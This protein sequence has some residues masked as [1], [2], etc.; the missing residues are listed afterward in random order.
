MNAKLYYKEATPH[1]LNELLLQSSHI[2]ANPKLVPS[3][4]WMLNRINAWNEKDNGKSRIHWKRFGNLWG[5]DYPKVLYALE[6]LSLLKVTRLKLEYHRNNH[7]CYSYEVTKTAK[8]AL[9]DTNKEYLYK[10]LTD[11]KQRRKTT[12]SI[13]KRGYNKQHFGDVRDFLKATVDGISFN[14]GD[15]DKACDCMDDGK[16]AFTYS[17]LISIVKKDYDALDFNAKDGRVWT[18]YAQ[19]PPEIKAIIKV[20]GLSLQQVMDIRSCYPSLWAK[21]V[22]E[23]ICNC[24]PAVAEEVE[25]YNKLFLVRENDPKQYLANLLGIDRNAIKEVLIKYFNGHRVSKKERDPFYKFDQYLQATFPLLYAT[26]QQSD[27]K[28]TGNNIGKYFETRLMLD[29][30]IYEKA[31]L[32][33]IVIGYEYD[34]MSFYSKDKSNCQALISFIEAKSVELLGIK[35]VFVD[36]TKFDVSSILKEKIEATIIAEEK[37][38]NNYRKGFFSKY[39]PS[40]DW[41]A[42]NARKAAYIGNQ[43]KRFAM[44]EKVT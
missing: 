40:K 26:W 24:A 2:S 34:G 8:A 1:A 6:C 21:Y 3:I 11:P 17:L 7:K 9:R 13:S 44:L 31:K 18:P 10:L 25:R 4:V 43:T 39:N 28:Q 35:L 36:K 22:W 30:S 42:L 27:I 5:K 12:K 20:N 33:G 41:D 15:I 37:Q 14:I 23:K 19:L 38:W 32:L 16:A 29:G